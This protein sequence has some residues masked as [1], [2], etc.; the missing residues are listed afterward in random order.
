MVAP[1]HAADLRHGDVALVDDQ[2]R[3]LGQ[4]LEQRRR[5]IALLAAGQVARVV[6]DSLAGA[7]GLDH[8]QVEGAAL[9]QPLGLQQLAAGGELV[10]PLLQLLLDQDRRLVE[11]RARRHV[12]A[13]GIDVDLVEIAGLLAGERIELDDAV[14]LVA[15]Q[16][17]APGAVLVLRREHVDRL[18]AHPEGAAREAGVVATVLQLDQRLDQRVARDLAAALQLDH[19]ARIGLDRADAVDAG[20]GGH[21]D[22]VVAFQQRLRG[23]MAHAVDL[24]VDRAV[25]LDVGVRARHIGFGLVVVVVADEILHRVVGKELLHLAVELGRQRLVR[26]QDQGRLLHRLDHLGHGEGLARAGDAQQHLVALAR[27]HARHQLADRRR[28]VAGRLVW[29]HHLHLPRLRLGRLTVRH[30]AFGG[31]KH[32][33]GV[34]SGLAG[35]GLLERRRHASKVAIPPARSKRICGLGLPTGPGI[36]PVPTR[37]EGLRRPVWRGSGQGAPVP[38]STRPS[39]R[40]DKEAAAGGTGAA[41]GRSRV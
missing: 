5:R 32:R 39:P 13:V 3:V 34:A 10:E 11:R 37:V 26:R 22:D 35:C 20:H 4:I 31:R 16:A 12:V 23:R 29:R 28:L 36:R 38:S 6:L 18:A 7:G 17:D 30:E 8:L 2:Q 24:L 15:E 33:A 40:R 41:S 25:L 27:Q 19:H 1:L 14:D 21:D 9:L